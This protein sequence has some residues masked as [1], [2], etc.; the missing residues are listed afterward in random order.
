MSER[1]RQSGFGISQQ[2][3]CPKMKSEIELIRMQ[4]L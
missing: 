2:K 1:K 4:S 3:K